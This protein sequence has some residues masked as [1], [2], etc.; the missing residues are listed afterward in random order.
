MVFA[1]FPLP[2]FEINVQQPADAS[3]ARV[4]G[5]DNGKCMEYIKWVKNLCSYIKTQS[6]C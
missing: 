3:G 6:C 1:G 2:S 4:E 5:L